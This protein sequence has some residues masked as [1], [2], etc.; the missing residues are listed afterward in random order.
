MKPCD[1]DQLLTIQ[2]DP[3]NNVVGIKTHENGYILKKTASKFSNVDGIIM[4]NCIR[5]YI[6]WNPSEHISSSYQTF[7]F[8]IQDIEHIQ[9]VR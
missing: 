8:L 7:M 1:A 2:K 9:H 6:Q 4:R 5:V 3:S